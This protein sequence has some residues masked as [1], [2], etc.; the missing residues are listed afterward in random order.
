MTG[1]D[2]DDDDDD[3]YT[4]DCYDGDDGGHGVHFETVGSQS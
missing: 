4:E 3:D 1:A 2:D